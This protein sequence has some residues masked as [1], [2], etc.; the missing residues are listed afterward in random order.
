MALLV[1]L[2]FILAVSFAVHSC[3]AP[4]PSASLAGRLYDGGWVLYTS[5]TC[6]YCASQ[7]S[8]L[9]GQYRGTVVCGG[10]RL[11]GGI[12][13]PGCDQ[14]PAFPYWVN[15]NTRETRTGVQS[16]GEL[17]AMARAR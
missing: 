5:P 8:A 13:L 12:P 6:S 15:T 1:A 9:G 3:G 17:A 16:Q 7:L 10:A 14:V 11:G 4:R 2:F